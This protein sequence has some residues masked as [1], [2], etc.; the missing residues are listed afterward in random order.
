MI[1]C[2]PWLAQSFEL[3]S[4]MNGMSQAAPGKPQEQPRP[5]ICCCSSALTGSKETRKERH[6]HVLYEFVRI[7]CNLAANCELA[8]GQNLDLAL[9]C[10]RTRLSRCFKTVFQCALLIKWQGKRKRNIC[11]SACSNL[12]VLLWDWGANIQGNR[13]QGYSEVTK[14]A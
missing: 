12:A 11:C 3:I 7:G 9:T 10:H 5:F 14:W 4:Q 8:K 1:S 2:F 13:L 6:E